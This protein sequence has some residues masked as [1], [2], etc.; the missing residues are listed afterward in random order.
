MLTL[1]VPNVQGEGLRGELGRIVRAFSRMTARKMFGRAIKGF[2]RSLETSWNEERDD[3]HPH[4]HALLVVP[5][6]YFSKQ[7]DLWI[8][9]PQ[10]VSL[11]QSCY[12]SKG[13][14]IVDVRPVGEVDAGGWAARRGRT[15]CCA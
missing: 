15:R 9:Q 8:T 13:V 2:V 1:T 14:K 10:W 12:G 6:E 7:H 4:L 5:A 3:Y 11:W